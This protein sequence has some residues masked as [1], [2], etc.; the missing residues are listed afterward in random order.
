LIYW[1]IRVFRTQSVFHRDRLFH[2]EESNL[3]QLARYC[4][5]A[6]TSLDLI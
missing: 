6:P 4:A 3:S 5:C 2:F 1:R